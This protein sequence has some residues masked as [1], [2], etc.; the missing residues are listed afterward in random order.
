VESYSDIAPW[1]DEEQL[2]DI[3]NQQTTIISQL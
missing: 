3:N 2:T 1:W